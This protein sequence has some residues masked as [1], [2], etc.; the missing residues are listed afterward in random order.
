MT[1]NDDPALTIRRLMRT[2]TK[3]VMSTHHQGRD[4]WPYGSLVLTTAAL[5]GSP[6]LLLSDLAD[7]V[8]NLRLD[9]RASLLFDGTGGL[10]DPLAGARTSVLGRLKKV[11]DPAL[12]ARYLRFQPAAE[13]Y[14]SF[15]D[16]NLY[17]MRIEAAHLV[18]GFGKIHWLSR[19]QLQPKDVDVKA[20]DAGEAALVDRLNWGR[21]S[22]VSKALGV[23]KQRVI[24]ADPEGLDVQAGSRR[25]RLE[26]G[27]CLRTPRGVTGA[28]KR[29]S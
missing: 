17:R 15:G 10:K 5:D 29:M 6:L 28:L 2:G 20:W 16:F 12:L 11:K 1:Q 23:K 25:R 19:A 27:A 8:K 24:G 18:A 4:S 9:P 22:L 13:L 3:A 14:A 21:S 26:F 7:H